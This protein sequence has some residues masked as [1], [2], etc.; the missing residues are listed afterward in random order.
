VDITY[1]LMIPV[2]EWFAKVTHSYG[3]AILALTMLVR[4]IVW[5][6]VA[7]S[8]KSMQR[9]SQLQP[10]M[11]KIQERYKDQPE[12][13]QKKVMEF[14]GKNK[15]NPLGGCLPTLVQ[16][17]VLFALFATFTGPPFQDKP[18]PVK[19]VLAAAAD[20]GKV[21]VSQAPTSGANSPYVAK[22]GQ[23][24]K[25]AVQPG[26]TTMVFGKNEKG[27]QVEEPKVIDFHVISQEGQLPPGFQPKWKIGH[28]T[29][30]ATMAPGSGEAVFPTAGDVIIEATLPEGVKPI[31]VPIKVLPKNPAEEP[32]GFLAWM[33]PPQDPFKEKSAQSAEQSI[34]TIDG[35]DY[36]FVVS[37]GPSTVVAGRP[38]HF[39][40][41][42]LEGVPPPP[43]FKVLWRI[44]KDPNAAAVD[45]QGKATFPRPGEVTVEAVIPGEAA[46]EPFYFINSIG[47]V[48]KGME[49][50]EPQNWD[51]LGMILL[52]AVTMYLSSAL[53]STPTA[54]M[55]PEQA[56]IQ[57]QTQQTMPIAL[58]AM[59]FFIPLPAGVYLYMVFSNVVQSLQTWLLMRKPAP[60]LVDV[61]DDTDGGGSQKGGTIDIDYSVEGSESDSDSVKLTGGKKK[62]KKKR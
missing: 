16:L 60:A 13:M 25:V 14:Y 31:Q 1:N 6:L 43:N 3:W 20:E 35:K 26:D 27:E 19:V 57:K 33:T 39:Q 58:T 2:L 55:D 62:S 37:P 42:T 21:K 59:F 38:V 34:A 28:D 18:V 17:P 49:L 40:L 9:M 4:I 8:T 29:N 47:K 5:P 11:K 23:L 51:V 56:A 50:L 52:F 7:S 41:K 10:M 45:E 15:V 48:P 53:M 24:A 36:T 30:A 61:L 46:K 32:P 54:N 22:D 44:A 12:I